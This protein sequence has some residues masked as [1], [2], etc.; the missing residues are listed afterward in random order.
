MRVLI[1]DPEGLG[2]DFALRCAAADHEVRWCM[3]NKG[4]GKTGQGFRG[5]AMVDDWRT[6]MGWAR[7]GLIITTG[8]AKFIRD[9]DRFRDL[10][11]KIFAPTERSAA[12][13]INR[14]LG[15]AEMVK[16]G[17]EV[18]PY[19]EFKTLKEAEAFAR[20]SDTAYAFKTLGSEEDKALSYVASDPADMVGW[21][22]RQQ[23]LGMKLKGPC[24][25]QEKIDM[26]AEVGVSG[27][28]GPE[29]FLPEKWQVCFEHKKLMAGENGPNTGEQG[30]IC[31]YVEMDRMASDMLKPMENYLL[32]AGHR[33]DFAI[34]CGIDKSGKAW[35]FEFT[36]RLGW[37]A[38]YIQIAS[39]RGDPA[40]WMR[41]LLDGEDTLRVSRDVGI[42]V[43][44]AQPCYPYNDSDPKMVEGVP[45]SGCDAVWPDLHPAEMMVG[46]GPIM[47]DGKVVDGQ[48]YETAGEYV[49]IMTARGD[50]VEKARNR[51]YR[52]ID[53][54]SFPNMM[55]R[56]DIGLKLEGQLPKLHDF[57]YAEE[58]DFS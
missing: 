24:M 8:N 27:W 57:G 35:P 26:L 50:S 48:V 52:S 30:T 32:K 2:L 15:M 31:Q 17:I 28:F 11:F 6:S 1:I 25:L 4:S 33:G 20:K 54:I 5:I 46:R 29:G 16:A 19:H 10:G 13:E 39:H 45:I 14:S 34:G 12:L 40:Q 23:K 58:M 53:Q 47:K 51:V 44:C 3:C 18:P 21:L 55:F 56:N 22:Q 9:L 38:F 49:L 43:V 36:A 7:D 42:G 37:P 41:D